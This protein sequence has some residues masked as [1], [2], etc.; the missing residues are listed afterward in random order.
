MGR[1]SFSDTRH[2]VGRTA[3]GAEW[4]GLK[5]LE[6]K[7]R[8]EAIKI[9]LKPGATQTPPPPRLT[10]WATLSRMSQRNGAGKQRAR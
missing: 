10:P 7:T 9:L 3:L 5:A 1:L 2:L 8:S 6:G 4:G